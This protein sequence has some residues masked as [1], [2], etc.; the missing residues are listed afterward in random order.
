MVE[1]VTFVLVVF[2]GLI[3]GFVDSVIGAGGLISIPFLIF[4]GVPPQV[5]IAT[6]KFGLLGHIFGSIPKFWKEKKIVWKYVPLLSLLGI[7]G[8]YIGT[9]IIIS[10]NEAALTKV[11]GFAILFL[12]PVVFFKKDLGLIKKKVSNLKKI[13]RY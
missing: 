11:V 7:I 10:V 1:L 9:K 8:G 2:V 5:A 12:L 13:I 3:T 4:T 6:D